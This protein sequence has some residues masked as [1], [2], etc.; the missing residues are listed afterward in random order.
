MNNT[1]TRSNTNVK[2]YCAANEVFMTTMRRADLAA[3]AVEV[4]H[5][6][7]LSELAINQTRIALTVSGICIVKGEDSE[8]RGFQ[9]QMWLEKRGER[10]AWLI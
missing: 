6:A 7:R 2:V 3:P 1:G 10:D 5:V 9:N 8:S 4:V